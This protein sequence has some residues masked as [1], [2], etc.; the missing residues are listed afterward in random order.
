MQIRTPFRSRKA[1][2]ETDAVAAVEIDVVAVAAEIASAVDAD[3]QLKHQ[4]GW[5]R[6]WSQPPFFMPVPPTKGPT[7]RYIRFG[8]WQSGTTTSIPFGKR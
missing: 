1:E 8:L 7:L 3:L 5:L 2:I 6:F 4:G